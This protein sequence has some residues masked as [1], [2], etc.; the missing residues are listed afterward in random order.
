MFR[1]DGEELHGFAVPEIELAKLWN[2]FALF[3]SD[4]TA[5]LIDV[6]KLRSSGERKFYNVTFRGISRTFAH[7]PGQPSTEG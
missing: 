4:E 3:C 7:G 1:A 2:D 5:K 6:F